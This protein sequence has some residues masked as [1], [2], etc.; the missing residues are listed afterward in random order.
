MTVPHLESLKLCCVKCKLKASLNEKKEKEKYI[1]C[2][3]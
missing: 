2:Y 1:N 3:L